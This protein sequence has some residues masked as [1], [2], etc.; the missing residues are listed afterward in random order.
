MG[1]RSGD[2]LGHSRT[3]ICFFLSHS[4][5]AL[6]IC[7]G[8]LSCWKTHPRPIFSALTEG[9]RLSPKI[10]RYMAPFILPSVSRPV[11]LAEK[12]PQSIRFPPP[13]F[14]VGMVFLGLYSILVSSDH[15]TFSQASSGSSRCSLANFRRACTCAFFSRGT[16]RAQQDFNPSRCNVLLMVLFV[17]VV[18]TAFPIAPTVVN[19]S[20][21]CLLIF[22]VS[23]K[24]YKI[25]K[26]SNNYC[27]QCKLPTCQCN[28]KRQCTFKPGISYWYSDC[29]TVWQA[30]V[31]SGMSN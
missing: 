23:G 1:F 29:L 18:P 30:D 9:R 3:L 25:S 12:H 31:W 8:S 20:P 2:W 4:F 24:T 19:F 17:T 15:I 10:S 5:V 21:S 26:G 28:G 16:L 11:P 7:F 6:A 27:S 22:F 14:T 13:C